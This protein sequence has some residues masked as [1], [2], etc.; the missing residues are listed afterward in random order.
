MAQLSN[1]F[2]LPPTELPELF[3]SSHAFHKEENWEP[4]PSVY[5][6]YSTH[7]KDSS[8]PNPFKT[9]PT[10]RVLDILKEAGNPQQL[11]LVCKQFCAISDD[12][13]FISLIS[14]H[15]PEISRKI[16]LPL[17][18]PQFQ[19]AVYQELTRE[20]RLLNLDSLVKL[21]DKSD[22]SDYIYADEVIKAA[23]FCLCCSK[24]PEMEVNSQA[25]TSAQALLKEADRL[26]SEFSVKSKDFLSPLSSLTIL[27]LS[28]LGLTRLPKEIC[29][30]HILG[31]LDLSY[32]FLNELPPEI[33]HLQ[34]LLKLDLCSN[35]LMELPPEIGHL[36]A[37]Q[38]LGLN[39]N[40]L[41]ELPPEI[42]NLKALQ[43]L[44]L[45]Y[46]SLIELPPQIGNLQA[47]QLLFL[48]NNS[49]KEL[50]P[51]IGNLQALQLLFLN[52]NSLKELPPQ[53]GNLQA[54]RNLD[55]SHNCLSSLP[56]Q[57]SNLQGLTMINLSSNFLTSIPPQ[58]FTLPLA[59]PA[60]FRYNCLD[61][62]T[63]LLIETIN[64]PR[65]MPVVAGIATAAAFLR[66]FLGNLDLFL[67]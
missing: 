48:N 15:L 1:N 57:I 35:S 25:R 65:V 24:L 7:K 26:R 54:L 13:S 17:P 23:N 44:D 29:D 61:I 16:I 30:L 40:F 38:H 3:E 58:F 66:M 12:R 59:E 10:E 53:I 49:L 33:A 9:L 19:K 55:L 56:P 51:Q 31:N 60:H 28:N 63:K 45:S 11:S 21:T 62:K 5:T 36:Q 37:L 46:N 20:L 67:N 52:N 8:L 42:Y 64:P 18:R 39:N 50:P 43:G 47:L 41:I 14:N 4:D 22:I 6:V 2:G 27:D 34:A 32:N